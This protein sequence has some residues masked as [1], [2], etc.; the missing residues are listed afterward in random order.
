LAI[1][2]LK[3]QRERKLAQVEQLKKKLEAITDQGD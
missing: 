2:T 1:K 3:E